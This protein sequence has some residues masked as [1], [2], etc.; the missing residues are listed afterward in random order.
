[1]YIFSTTIA[2][3]G[4][5]RQVH[6]RTTHPIYIIQSNIKNKSEEPT[7]Q[8]TPIQSRCCFILHINL[9]TEN[10]CSDKSSSGNVNSPEPHQDNYP[11][12]TQKMDQRSSLS[13]G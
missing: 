6:H 9:V 10:P 13:S 2:Q 1:M 7:S 5:V 4:T 3:E 8:D 11:P 12:I